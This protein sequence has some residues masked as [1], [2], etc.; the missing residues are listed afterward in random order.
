[1]AVFLAVSSV[2]VSKANRNIAE[3]RKVE[4]LLKDAY[5]KIDQEVRDRTADLMEANEK[6]RHEIAGRRKADEALTRSE[7]F[8]GT[9]FDGIHDPFCI[10]DRQMRAVRVNE[11]YAAL[12]KSSVEELTGKKCGEIMKEWECACETC[13]VEKTLNS[14]DP[15]AK[16]KK[17]AMPGGREM[18]VEI[19]TYPIF[20]EEGRV[21]HV[22]EHTR[23]VTG[24]KKS[25]EERKLL[26]EKL[27]RLSRTDVLT[28]LLNRRG[29]R[30]RLEHEMD[31]A[32]RYGSGMSLIICDIDHFKD[33]NDRF[34]HDGGDRS[35]RFVAETFQ[36]VLR[37]SDV[38]GRYGGDEFM[39]ILPET[40]ID[41]AR[42]F[43]E[44]LCSLTWS[45]DVPLGG[46]F[47]V[48]MS[49]SIGVAAF[50]KGI[51]VDAESLI[52]QADQAMYASK[53]SGRNR[54]TVAQETSPLFSRETDMPM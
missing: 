7:K 27:E 54:V 17:V 30:E 38:L 26:I 20:D 44:R 49:L 48:R 28:G 23:D 5:V 31:R 35:L 18:W 53:R 19:Y 8:L 51:V 2:L 6:L 11:A 37:K 14:A 1:M 12:K 9:I 15:C 21:S 24:R 47:S 13:I 36:K 41:G 46:E 52:R 29:L 16:D 33:I 10:F 34:G 22:I 43:A 50:Q 4:D 42:D 45:S 39:L 3:R 25:E 32:G 40:G